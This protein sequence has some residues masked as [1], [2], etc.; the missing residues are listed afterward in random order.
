MSPLV[1]QRASVT[2]PLP[3][4]IDVAERTLREKLASSGAAPVTIAL[5]PPDAIALVEISGFAPGER[6]TPRTIPTAS[7]VSRCR[8]TSARVSSNR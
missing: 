1:R 6:F 7:R 2:D 4:W 3:A 8:T 5:E